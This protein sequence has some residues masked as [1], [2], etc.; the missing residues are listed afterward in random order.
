MGIQS[1]EKIVNNEVEFEVAILKGSIDLLDEILNTQLFDILG[2]EECTISFKTS[3]Y[4]KYFY[5]NLIDFISEIDSSFKLY[6]KDFSLFTCLNKIS[7]SYKLGT[8]CDIEKLRAHL[9][10]FSKWLEYKATIELWC[11]N[12]NKN[13]K[14]EFSRYD[15][16]KICGNIS[17]HGI[18]RLGRTALNIQK[19]YKDNKKD[20]SFDVAILCLENFY[21]RVH[22]DIL[23]YYASFIVEMLLNIRWAINEYLKSI[24]IKYKKYSKKING[25]QTYRYQ[26]PNEIQSE[27]IKIMY[28]DLMND[29][30]A[31]RKFARI[32]VNKYLKMRY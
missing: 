8:E 13:V 16:L 31:N 26:I 29:V 4:Q 1:T 10:I 32:K 20:I 3:Y 9:V 12:I 19:I 21:E 27:V 7:E 17:K 5:L 14:L 24:Y 25:L 18:T 22:D 15:M 6:N 2:T 11:Y 30:R 23:N 28:W